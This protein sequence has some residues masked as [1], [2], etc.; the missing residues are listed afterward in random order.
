MAIFLKT[1]NP[2]TTKNVKT[3]DFFYEILS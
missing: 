1:L 3:G 2:Q